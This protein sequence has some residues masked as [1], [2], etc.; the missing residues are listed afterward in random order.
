MAGLAARA[1]VDTATQERAQLIV[2]AARPGISLLPGTV[3]QY[4][5][6]HARCPVLVVPAERLRPGAGWRTLHKTR[7]RRRRDEGP[8]A[9]QAQ[10]GLPVRTGFS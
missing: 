2:L 6:R 1:I 9:P 4:V 5:L 3:S 8:A 7:A 10:P